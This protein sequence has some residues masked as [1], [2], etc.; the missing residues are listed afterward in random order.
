MNAFDGVESYGAYWERM[1]RLAKRKAK[2]PRGHVECGFSLISLLIAIAVAG[3]LWMVAEPSFNS[4]AID[5]KNPDARL[6]YTMR[7][8]IANVTAIL[9]S[10]YLD[11]ESDYLQR[12]YPDTLDLGLDPWGNSYVFHKFTTIGKARK[13][14]N[15]VRTNGPFDLYSMGPDGK[16][17]TPFTSASGGDDIIIANN[18]AYIGVACFHY[19]NTS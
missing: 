3:I 15:L 16:T 11:L 12:G 14:H 19:R 7:A 17:A 2:A 10:A 8:K 13:D 1:A 5:C 4:N 18:G 6:G 9:G